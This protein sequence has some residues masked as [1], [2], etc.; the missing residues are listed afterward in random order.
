MLEYPLNCKS[1]AFP[2]LK[3]AATTMTFLNYSFELNGRTN[4]SN[5]ELLITF[6]IS[7]NWLQYLMLLKWY[8]LCDFTKYDADRADT[9]TIDLGDG[10]MQTI[11]KTDYEKYLYESGTNPYYTVTGPRVDVNLYL[12]D[13]F[14]N[15][16]CTFNYQG[17]W[18]KQIRNVDLDYAKTEGTEVECTFT[19][20]YYKYNVYN[21][22]K[23]LQEFIPSG[24]YYDGH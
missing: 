16:K 21:N 14:M 15:R 4:T 12:L 22:S 18:I 20:S 8:E 9:V 19:L 1:V 5:K 23:D 7:S 6:K 13:N 24:I 10:I 2:E 17:C 11:A 3:L